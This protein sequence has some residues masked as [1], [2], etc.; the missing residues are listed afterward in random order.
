M[1]ICLWNG[2]QLYN[3]RVKKMAHLEFRKCVVS[4]LIGV[5][6]NRRV[7]LRRSSQNTHNIMKVSVSKKCKVCHQKKLRKTLF[8]FVILASTI[9]AIQ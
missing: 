4:Y 5:P 6:Y 1:D 9:K 2:N 8:L 7:V 3:M